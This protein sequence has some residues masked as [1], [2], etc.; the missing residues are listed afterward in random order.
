VWEPRWRVLARR[1]GGWR[2][3]RRKNDIDV[4]DG[5][6]AL[7]QIGSSV[8]PSGRGRG[9]NKDDNSGG[10]GGSIS[11]SGGGSGSGFDLGDAL[12]VIGLILIVFVLA[13]VFFW[14]ILLPLLLLVIDLLAVV[15]LLIVATVGRVFFRRPWTIEARSDSGRIVREE[16]IGWRAALRRRDEI[17]L[18]LSQTGLSDR[19]QSNSAYRA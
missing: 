8:R 6:D 7:G 16:V 15:L 19:S 17:A 18:E 2:D 10:S 14:W 4:I 12:W 11:S 3:K 9:G 13:A 5:V 1:F